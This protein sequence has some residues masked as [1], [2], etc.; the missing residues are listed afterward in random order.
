[1]STNS[2]YAEVARGENLERRAARA[3]TIQISALAPM[4]MAR[5]RRNSRGSSHDDVG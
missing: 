5:P 4:R 1:M 3:M 2:G